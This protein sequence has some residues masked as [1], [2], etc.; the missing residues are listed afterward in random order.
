MPTTFTSN[1]FSSTYKDDFDSSDNFH[2]ILFNSGRALQARE[3]TQMQ[4]I[5]Q[6]EV[7]RF[8]RNIFT[9]GASVNPGGPSINNSYPFVKLATTPTDGPALVGTEL[10]GAVSTVKARV[11]EYVAPV[12][13]DPATIYVQYTN[14]S[15]GTNGAS[16]VTF[17][18]GESLGAAAGSVQTNNT[19]DDPAVGFGCKI[20]NDAGDFFVRGHFVRANSQGL[21]ISKYSKSPTTTVGFKVLEDIIT[22]TDDNSLYDNQG[23][24][25]NITSPGADRYRIRLELTTQ[26][27]VDAL[28]AG[29]TPTNFMYYCRVLDGLIVDQVRGTDNYSK[30]ND[31]LATRTKEESGNYIAKRF[32]TDLS[33]NIAKTKSLITVSPGLAYVN[34]YRAENEFATVLELDKARD[35][36]VAAAED[37]GVGYGQYFICEVLKGTLDVNT[38]D[39]ISLRSAI[40]FGGST[41][42]TARVRYVEPSGTQFKVY[43]FDIKMNTGEQLRN[44]KSFGTSTT[45]YADPLLELGKAIIKESNKTNLIFPLD[46]TRPKTISLPN[47]KVQRIITGQTSAGDGSLTVTG[48]LNS[49][50]ATGESFTDTS[51][52]IV[53]RN[54]T[55]AVESGYTVTG[56]GTTTL[57]FASLTASKAVTIYAKVN[58]TAP[59]TR[60]KTLSTDLVIARAVE[61]DGSA[62]DVTGIA[63]VNIGAT[64]IHS[65]SKI[66]QTDSTGADLSSLFTLDD[67][68]RSSHYG[69]GRLVLNGG[70]TPPTGNVYVK[71]KHFIHGDDGDFF[72]VNSYGSTDS[73]YRNIPDY[74]VN[75][76]TILN[77]RDVLDFRSS[78]DKDGEF[79]GDSASIS[80][81]P[82]NG[83]TVT[84]TAQY[85]LRRSD[86]IFINTQGVVEAKQGTSGFTSPV[87]DHPAGTLGLFEVEHNPFGL[88]AKDVVV[89]PIEAKRFTMKDIGRLEK[90]VNKLEEVTSLSLLELDTSSLLVLDSDGRP[91][92]K[93][94][95]FVD[96]FN[97]RSFTDVQNPE[98]RA[99]ID[100]TLGILQPQ[101]IEDNVILRYDSDKSSNTILKGDTVFIK[102]THTPAIEQLKVTGFENVNPFAVLTG[103]GN[104]QLSPASDEWIDTITLPDKVI[105]ETAVEEVGDPLLLSVSY[106][107]YYTNNMSIP[108]GGF[109]GNMT[110]TP[111]YHQGYCGAAIYNQTGNILSETPGDDQFVK[112]PDSPTGYSPRISYG[113]Y[114]INEI[115]DTVELSRISIPF[116]RPRIVRFKAEGLRPV[117]RFW[118]FF[119]GVSVDAYVNQADG[120]YKN[121]SS[122]ADYQKLSSEKLS[123]A[124]VHPLGNTQLVSDANGKIEGSFFIPNSDT[125]RFSTGTRE[126]KLLDISS[127]NDENATSRAA[128]NYTASG[129]LRE[130]QNTVVSTRV[131]QVRPVIWTDLEQVDRRDPLAQTF[132]VTEDYG[133]FATKID[134]FIKSKDLAIPIE[135]QIRPVVNGVPSSSN[136]IANAIK[137]VN[138]GA[139]TLPASQTTAAVLAVPTTF[140]F[141]EPIFLQPDTEYAIVVLAESKD[142]EVYVAETQQFELGSTEKKIN[143]QPSLGSLFK[144]QNGSTWEPD[145]TKDLMFRIYKA[146]FDVADGYAVFENG[147]V[148]R[149]SLLEN[150]LYMADSDATVTVLVPNHSLL[151]GDSIDI[152]GLDSDASTLYNG[153]PSARI[154]GSRTIT[155]VDGFGFTFE[156]DSAATSSGR[157][158]GARGALT[159]D[160]QIGMDG[161]I[162]YFTSLLPQTTDLKYNYQFTTGKSLAGAETPYQKSATYSTDIRLGQENFFP[163]PRLIASPVAE[164]NTSNFAA[165]TKSVTFKVDMTT[166]HANVSPLIDAQRTSLITFRNM[167]DNQVASSAVAG[168]SNVPLGYVAET[169][170]FGGSS[171]SKHMTSV[172]TLEESSVG[173]KIILGALRPKN[174]HVDL[175]YRVGTDGANIFNND[176]IL[177]SPETDVAPDGR[178]FREYRYLVGG[179]KG[180]LDAFTQYQLKIVMRGTNSS[181]VPKIKD[182]RSIAMAV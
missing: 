12:G 4:T 74:K 1:V 52:I 130:E 81:M 10:T 40:T 82:K 13:S 143:K 100:P 11:L 178:R 102:H 145:Q 57:T 164:A 103:I 62:S 118:P 172:Q 15:G 76:R 46:H 168:E 176:W 101:T 29:G 55:G 96:N 123:Y 42:G 154:M 18:A 104:L 129:I 138:P 68:Q 151:V 51:E 41:V 148:Q 44:I 23:T 162:P 49:G 105:E 126:F 121:M 14:T 87:P 175:Y 60:S 106:P 17:N 89:R 180:E 182:L 85:Y 24:T 65:V 142:Y 79:D 16:A 88:T 169:N 22:A 73:D 35:L 156:A 53:V 117:T 127:N 167:I 161:V 50:S 153:I 133:M 45:N 19:V 141:D 95:F 47:Y 146:V 114:V 137:F 93:S 26:T 80:E 157:F 181:R 107:L 134:L 30:I 99:A 91:R 173:L 166:K 67:G 136:I 90:R 54:D 165:G 78:V 139:I 32:T 21:I 149:Q 31:L 120:A 83:D 135:V 27:L 75:E 150:P 94:G 98:Y 72:S 25:P 110:G 34:G 92:S 20:H 39:T 108:I 64:D 33:E 147:A 9:E 124:E 6:E 122:D 152:R 125:L 115:T 131:E 59:V 119:D 58:K 109:T 38:F 8:G 174:S 86:K 66:L 70:A 111:Y 144:S 170:A 179:V 116:I 71:Y 7:E 158:G 3:L 28:I 140:E 69:L 177:I 113:S 132:L 171:L 61:S 160:K 63:Y 112:D 43:L 97:D 155:A 37:A 163:T 128:R 84:F 5:I 36:S 56:A 159:V 77:L 48:V 2:R